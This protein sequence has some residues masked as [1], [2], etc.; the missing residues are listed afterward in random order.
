[1]VDVAP[2]RTTLHPSPTV[3]GIDAHASHR[4]EVDDDPVVASGGARHVV[5]SAPYG[6]LQIV[7]ASEAH[8]RDHVRGPDASGDQVRAPVNGAVPDCTGDV[9]VGVVGADKATSA[10]GDTNDTKFSANDIATIPWSR[11]VARYRRRKRICPERVMTTAGKSETMQAGMRYLAAKLANL[12][13]NLG[14]TL[15][16]P[17]R[18]EHHY[19]RGPGPKWHSR[20]GLAR[21]LPQPAC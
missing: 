14:R 21:S 15:S 10:H 18:P 7:I 3:G 1:V 13:C 19:M 2:Q 8:R 17:Y 20:Q 6:N 4:R 12:F 16:D 5:A 11:N 9:I